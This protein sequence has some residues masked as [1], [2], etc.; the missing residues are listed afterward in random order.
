MIAYIEALEKIFSV[1]P[2]PKTRPI[3]LE[4]A[5]KF[6]LAADIFCP[7]DLPAFDNSA[8][9]GYAVRSVDTHPAKN[10][11]RVKLRI[12]A[13]SVAGHQPSASLNQGECIYITTGAMIPDGADAVVP[14][15]EVELEQ[16][17]IV[18]RTGPVKKQSHIRYS[19]EEMSA[20]SLVFKSGTELQAAHLGML[21][22]IGMVSPLVYKKPSIGF[23]ATGDEL[24]APETMPAGGQIRNSNT[25]MMKI[26]VRNTGCKFTD[27]G[28]ARDNK[29]DLLQILQAGRWPDV[30]ITSA[31]VS[32]GKYD[33]VTS[34]LQQAGLEVIF[35]KVAVKPGK[36]LV[37]GTIKDTIFFGLPGNP[38]SGA[39][40]FRQFIEPALIAM[41]GGRLP[42]RRVFK[43]RSLDVFK[44]TT[45]RLN[46]ARGYARYK[47]GWL[48]ESAGKQASHM[49]S[50]LAGSN[51][52]VLIPPDKQ[53]QA[54]EEVFIQLH[55]GPFS[56]WDEFRRELAGFV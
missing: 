26:M 45:G 12:I 56:S 11:S 9:D 4:D 36:P 30:L 47:D 16:N 7:A 2:R 55:E 29:I 5:H 31:G 3:R 37:F 23:I 42:F 43:A 10:S 25:T 18:L 32:M 17:H 38:V 28:I 44:R 54:G 46:F 27:M 24:I 40:V 1:L 41:S 51:C 50:G 48:V 14:V 22:S 20:G 53:V 33:T 35:W 8:M 13:E 6:Y 34:T 49:L 19:G 39:V 52:L 21:A 15:E